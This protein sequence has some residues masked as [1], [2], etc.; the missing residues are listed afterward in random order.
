MKATYT[1]WYFPARSRNR[2][3]NSYKFLAWVGG[4]GAGKNWFEISGVRKIEGSKI[5]GEITVVVITS[6]R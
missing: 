3:Q 1:E 2:R 5:G 6:S 4:G